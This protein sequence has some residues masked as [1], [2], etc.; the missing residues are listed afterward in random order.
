MYQD[1]HQCSCFTATQLLPVTPHLCSVNKP[2]NSV[3]TQ[4]QYF[5]L[6]LGPYDIVYVSPPPP[7]HP[8]P[9]QGIPIRRPQSLGSLADHEVTTDPLRPHGALL[10]ETQL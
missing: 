9:C 10:S 6:S 4:G 5:G 8:S 1:C 7:G 2:S 3:V